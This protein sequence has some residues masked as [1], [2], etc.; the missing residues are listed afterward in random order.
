MLTEH[1]LTYFE[2]KPLTFYRI[3]LMSFSTH[4]L[5]HT[6]TWHGCTTSYPLDGTVWHEAIVFLDKMLILC[7]RQVQR[8]AE[9]K[10]STK[11]LFDNI[12]VTTNW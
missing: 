8:E 5:Q 7:N 2:G 3:S 9:L 4:L 12:T 1:I 11:L 6:H 10:D